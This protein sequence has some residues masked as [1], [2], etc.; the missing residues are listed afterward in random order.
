MIIF[1][2]AFFH[3]SEYQFLSNTTLRI[4]YSL[5]LSSTYL[6]DTTISLICIV[7]WF[8]LISMQRHQSL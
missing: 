2:G 1:I 7:L 8:K 6:D 3:L 5:L 4:E